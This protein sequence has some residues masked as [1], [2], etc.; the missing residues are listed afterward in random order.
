MVE[1][2]Q[3]T[4]KKNKPLERSA[5]Q[6]FFILLFR[7]IFGWLVTVGRSVNPLHRHACNQTYGHTDR[8]R[9]RGKERDTLPRFKKK[10]THLFY[11]LIKQIEKKNRNE[12]FLK[13]F[14]KNSFNL[15]KSQ[16]CISDNPEAR[17]YQREGLFCQNALLMK[18][19]AIEK[20]MLSFNQI[21]IPNE[22]RKKKIQSKMG[23]NRN[24]F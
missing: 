22:K 1:K 21:P 10:K 8:N 15:D 23:T 3:T 4:S 20:A 13:I 17:A 9:E 14:F 19:C 16:V 7:P 24:Y 2:E 11:Q 18:H 12:A 5:W 6:L